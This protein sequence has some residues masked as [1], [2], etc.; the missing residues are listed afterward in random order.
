MTAG[1]GR[2]EA[3]IPT[4]SAAPSPPPTSQGSQDCSEWVLPVICLQ[5]LLSPNFP[6]MSALSPNFPTMSPALSPPPSSQGSQD[7]SEWVDLRRHTSDNALRKPGQYASWPVLGPAASTPYR[8]FR[9]VLTGPTTSSTAPWAF[10]LSNLELYGYLTR[11]DA[12]PATAAIAGPGVGAGPAEGAGQGLAATG[13]GLASV[14][15]QGAGRGLML[16]VVGP[17]TGAGAA[18]VVAGAMMV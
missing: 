7:C 15:E 10:C 2:K 18:G 16:G 6:T 14:P 5:L 4:V 9:F 8:A 11:L 1:H 12:A 17:G 3:H 13:A